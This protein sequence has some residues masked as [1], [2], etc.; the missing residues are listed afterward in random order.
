MWAF[1]TLCRSLFEHLVHLWFTGNSKRG[2]DNL[3]PQHYDA[4]ADYLTEVVRQ[5]EVQWGIHFDYLAPFNEP[6]EGFWNIDRKKPAQEGC[7]FSVETI[8]KV[9]SVP[10]RCPFSSWPGERPDICC[11]DA[12]A[13]LKVVS[14][15]SKLHQRFKTGVWSSEVYLIPYFR[16]KGEY[17]NSGYFT[18]W[19]GSCFHA[20]IEYFVDPRLFVKW[21]SHWFGRGYQL[22]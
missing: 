13:S 3:D 2:Q 21:R 10:C 19:T 22:R 9:F 1:S 5:Y 15:D 17:W 11:E 7:N 20:N 8:N 4:F 18:N 16:S 6:V 12:T 14:E